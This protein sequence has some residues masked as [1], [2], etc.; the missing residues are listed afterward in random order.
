MIS[1]LGLVSWSSFFLTSFQ[2]IISNP[3]NSGSTM[4][5]G[6][7]SVMRLRS[8]HCKAAM[9]VI[10][11]VHEASLKKSDVLMGGDDGSRVLR[12]NSLW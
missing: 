1:F 7:S 10:N 2:V 9:T 12:P 4:A 11:F 3:T 5:T 6:S 8:T